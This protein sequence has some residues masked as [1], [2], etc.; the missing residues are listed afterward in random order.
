MSKPDQVFIWHCLSEV[1][2]IYRDFR[3][4]F[5]GPRG[6]IPVRLYDP[7]EDDS[8]SITRDEIIP[9]AV[10]QCHT[11]VMLLAGNE[12]VDS[13]EFIQLLQS[14]ADAPRRIVLSL[15]FL[16][17]LG[18]E[19]WYTNVEP[20]IESLRAHF[21]S[22]VEIWSRELEPA[23]LTGD[24]KNSICVRRVEDLRRRIEAK[25]REFDATP[26]ALG[27]PE[28][29]AASGRQII[30]L[31]PT[32]VGP[33]DFGA[34]LTSAIFALPTPN[35]QRVVP[36]SWPAG[37]QERSSQRAYYDL[38]TQPAIFVRIIG[39]ASHA[40][41]SQSD[42]DFRKDIRTALGLDA[43]DF[44][45]RWDSIVRSLRIDWAPNARGV[46]QSEASSSLMR[47][48]VGAGELALEL[49]RALGI[50][51]RAPPR[52]GYITIT[53]NDYRSKLVPN[54]ETFEGNLKA[55]LREAL[56]KVLGDRVNPTDPEVRPYHL[57]SYEIMIDKEIQS[58]TIPILLAD[59][60]ATS[61]QG[62]DID[63]VAKGWETRIRMAIGKVGKAKKVIRGALIYSRAE[64]YKGEAKLRDPELDS[65]FPLVI[66]DEGKIAE[67]QLTALTSEVRKSFP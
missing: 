49:G 59:D 7:D 65:W 37:W 22:P 41:V 60:L 56:K 64:D 67:N 46:T 58:G 38:L 52:V 47:A 12:T 23:V 53:L 44:S 28:W 25:V 35:G 17:P 29:G 57:D 14:V 8:F 16:R 40:Q 33:T 13:I 19:W 27:S 54:A 45:L 15:V 5:A 34:D 3:D 24:Q 32:G 6:G 9:N 66:N 10:A 39:D 2:D 43:I 51:K 18:K 50:V 4:A 55:G 63:K 31:S 1:P 21:V 42:E 48:G 26:M 11:V 62:P 36:I 61:A 30:L 20:K